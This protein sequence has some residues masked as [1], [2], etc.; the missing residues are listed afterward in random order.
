MKKKRRPFLTPEEIWES[1]VK[2]CL[3]MAKLVRHEMKIDNVKYARAC[4]RVAD[5]MTMSIAN[6]RKLAPKFLVQRDDT[7]SRIQGREMFLKTIMD[8]DG[9]AKKILFR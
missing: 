3:F 1:R 5:K 7:I 8:E 4:E 9:K 2:R 6:V